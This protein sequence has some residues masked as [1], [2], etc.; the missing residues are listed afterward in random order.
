MLSAT[1][2][3]LIF[4]A[5]LFL[6]G[7]GMTLAGVVI[8]TMRAASS[9]VRTLAVQTSKLA[10]KGIA[11]EITGL[12]GNAADLLEAM[13]QLVRTTQGIGLFL[14]VLGVILMAVA[15]WLALEVFRMNS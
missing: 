2:L 9:D 4:S 14:T 3:I 8:L 7:A 11:Y 12:V 13:N 6:L 1:S 10:Q 5:L 15:S